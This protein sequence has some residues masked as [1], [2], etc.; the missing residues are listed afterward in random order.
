MYEKETELLNALCTIKDPDVEKI[1]SL[2]VEPLDFAYLLGKMIYSN[3]HELVWYMICTHQ[4]Q[5][6]LNREV[7]N[8]LRLL[9]ERINKGEKQ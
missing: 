7:R 8:T 6:L 9:S 1:K 3:V 2:L 4:V 5:A